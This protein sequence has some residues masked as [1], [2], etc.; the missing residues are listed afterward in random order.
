MTAPAPDRP[1][2]RSERDA[3]AAEGR[4]VA[5]LG[6]NTDSVSSKLPKGGGRRRTWQL[7]D[8]LRT[9]ALPR[10][11]KCGRVRI[12]QLVGVTMVDGRAGFNGIMTCGLAWGCPV[13]RAKIQ[14]ERAKEVMQT[15]EWHRS[16]GGETYLLTLTVRH[17]LGH[18]L[19]TMRKGIANAWR[20]V[21][22]GR[23]WGEWKQRT[24]FVG[25]IRALET[26]HGAHGWHP[27]IH[28]LILAKRASEADVESWRKQLSARWQ[29]AVERT[30]GAE[31]R[32]T[33][34]KGCDMRVSRKADYIAKLG[35]EVAGSAGKRARRGNRSPLEIAD[36]WTTTWEH[37]D[38]VLWRT[39]TKQMQG[40][41]MLTWSKG[42]RAAVGLGAE[43]TD[44]ELAALDEQYQP[45][46]LIQAHLWDRLVRVPNGPVRVLEAMERG[47]PD[48]L[49]RMLGRLLRQE[50]GPP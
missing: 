20:K 33:D 44:E 30:L 5:P 9:M 37:D 23:Q 25:S 6:K 39:Y 18:N 4:A 11:A 13:C 45:V 48:A 10:A 42:L 28:V 19:R 36:D 2:E 32:P 1:S 26:T 43:R 40:A 24:G 14:S 50:R 22:A 15:V 8:G 12:A 29:L 16:R 3:V 46:M 21:Q 17:A 38:G 35:L 47:G 34:R 7:R 27:H 41:R 49:D 31:H